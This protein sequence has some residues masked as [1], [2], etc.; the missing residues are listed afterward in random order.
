MQDHP[1]SRVLCVD[2][3]RDTCELL[4]TALPHLSFTFAH[5]LE[6][7]LKLARLGQFDLFLL[8]NWLP[9][10]SGIHL[11][12]EIRKVDANTPVVFLSAA[13]YHRD[14]DEAMASGA[15]AYIDKP[16]DL[17]QLAKLLAALIQRAASGS[18]D[19]GAGRIRST[20]D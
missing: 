12:R 15:N 18:L 13:S 20:A 6:A 7:G 8:D 9:D 16:V 2:D 19:A 10:G 11:C 14:H 17:D 1:R 3:N 4:S 5:S